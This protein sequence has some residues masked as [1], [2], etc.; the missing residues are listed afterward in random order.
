MLE[1]F[2]S[3]RREQRRHCGWA[4]GAAVGC[5]YTPPVAGCG[6]RSHLPVQFESSQALRE[7][8]RETAAHRHRVT[9]RMSK[10]RGASLIGIEAVPNSDRAGG[11]KYGGTYGE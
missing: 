4:G 6:P 7:R 3:W 8:A 1:R 10:N 5:C 9:K 2:A 11:P